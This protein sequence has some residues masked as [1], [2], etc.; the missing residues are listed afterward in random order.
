MKQQSSWLQ[1]ARDLLDASARDID[2]A[3]LSRL[4]RARQNALQASV[5][6]RQTRPRLWG[7]GFAAACAVVLAVVVSIPH[8]AVP[9]GAPVV[10]LQN[11][12]SDESDLVVGD[13][14]LE[15]VQDLEFYAWLDTEED[16]VSG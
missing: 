14:N 10:A 16:D 2:A 5:P 6:G 11:A 4:N 8:S 13:D 15:I 12:S 7:A 1:Q 3:S 9:T